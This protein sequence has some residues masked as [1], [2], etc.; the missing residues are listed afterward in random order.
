MFKKIFLKFIV[1]SLTNCKG[2]KLPNPPAP[3]GGGGANAANQCLLY[4]L[5]VY[6]LLFI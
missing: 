5:F 3:F 1:I 4:C 2:E 6:L